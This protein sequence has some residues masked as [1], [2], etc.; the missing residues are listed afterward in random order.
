M[1]RTYRL[2]RSYV[3]S[4]QRV[5]CL[6]QKAQK[7][8]WRGSP[9]LLHLDV[10]PETTRL[11]A[12]RALQRVQSLPT[13]KSTETVLAGIPHAL[14]HFELLQKTPTGLPSGPCHAKP[15]NHRRCCKSMAFLQMRCI[16]PATKQT[17][18]K[19]NLPS[20]AWPT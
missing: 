19:W 15:N 20:A 4:L 9:A 12:Q 7:L 8:S 14:L 16:L 6:Q 17:K 13:T 2:Y 18:T 1:P 3:T 11:L 5:Q 10:L